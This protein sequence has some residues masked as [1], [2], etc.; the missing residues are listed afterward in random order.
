VARELRQ[1]GKSYRQIVTAMGVSV[2]TIHAAINN[3]R[4]EQQN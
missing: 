3:A 4:G 1:E 2:A